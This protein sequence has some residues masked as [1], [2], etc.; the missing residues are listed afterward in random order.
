MQSGHDGADWDVE[1]ARCVGVGE[2]TD[3]DQDDHVAEIVR[4]GGERRDDVVLGEPLDDPLLVEVAVA[5]VL[6]QP[7]VEVLGP[8]FERL[9]VR[10]ALLAAPAVDV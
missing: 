9:L 8:F 10:R 3:V 4:H 7:V 5:R 2:V 1:D 6:L